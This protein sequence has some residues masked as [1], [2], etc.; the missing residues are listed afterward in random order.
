MNSLEYTKFSLAICEELE[1]L[2]GVEKASFSFTDNPVNSQYRYIRKINSTHIPFYLLGFCTKV[3]NMEYNIGVL[4]KYKDDFLIMK[5]AEFLSDYLENLWNGKYNSV[6]LRSSYDRH[7][8][9]LELIQQFVDNFQLLTG[10]DFMTVDDLSLQNYESTKCKGVL[11]FLEESASFV[12]QPS[13]NIKGD[14]Y[15]CPDHLRVIRKLI[16]GGKDLALVFVRQRT[17]SNPTRVFKFKGYTN[18]HFTNQSAQFL[19]VEI[20]GPRGA[21]AGLG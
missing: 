8:I 9:C 21:E 13:V 16:A 3:L 4:N 1:T 17:P 15:F 11:Y 6:N 2:L 5:M 14:I 19:S 20:L 18:E 10:I 7:A 12:G